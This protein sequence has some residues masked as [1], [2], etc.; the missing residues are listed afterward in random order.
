MG[1]MSAGLGALLALGAPIAMAL[2]AVTVGFI[3]YDPMLVGSFPLVLQFR[4]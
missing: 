3:V 2:I 4:E 1:S